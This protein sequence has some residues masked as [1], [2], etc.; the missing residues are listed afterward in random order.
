MGHSTI[1]DIISS[2]IVA[3]MLL[4]ITLRLN[5]QANETGALYNSNL[6]L[7]ENM[8]SLVGIVEHDFRR[9]GYCADYTKIPEPSLSIRRADSNAIRFWTDVDNDGRLDSIYYYLG[10]PDASTINPNDK[11][12]YRK[13]N[14]Q[15]AQPLQLGVTI[16]RFRYFDAEG[17]TLTFPINDPREVYSMEITIGIEAPAPF[18]VLFLQEEAA[19]AD[20]QQFWRQLR[21][22]ARNLRN[23]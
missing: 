16:F 23:R 8:S 21:L 20:F 3:G 9:I 5:M 4:L 10:G 19:R 14:N 17:D 22:A 11:I 15:T 12:L 2:S 7:Q 6:T 18:Q 13:V 1:L